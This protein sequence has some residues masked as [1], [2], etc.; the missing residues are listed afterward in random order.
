M[1]L[2]VLIVALLA[3]T[4][5]KQA[6]RDGTSGGEDALMAAWKKA[7]LEV[8]AFA[9]IDGGKYGAGKCKEGA[10]SNVDV[11]LCAY[12]DD[13]AAAAAQTAGLDAVGDTTGA[14]I[15]VGPR[16]LVVADRAGKDPEGKTINAMLKAFRGK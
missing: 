14:A 9:A 3:V 2:A 12:A 7:G 8:G 13:K 16:L 10:V 5:C 15:A 11:V 4:G 6:D 1:R